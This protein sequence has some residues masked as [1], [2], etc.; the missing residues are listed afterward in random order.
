MDTLSFVPLFLSKGDNFWDF[1][2]AYMD[3]I[4]LRKWS[5]LLNAR[6]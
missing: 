3:N 5:L 1:M 2:I 6:S 4:A